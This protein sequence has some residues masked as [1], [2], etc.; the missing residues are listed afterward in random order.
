MGG[1]SRHEQLALG[2][3]PNIAAR[4]Q[5]LAEPNSVVMSA[6]TQR[7]VAGLFNCQDLGPQTL[8]GISIP[9]S[10]YRVSG[11]GAAQSRFDAAM[12]KGLTPLVGRAEELSL[13]QRR[14]EQ[15][16]AGDGQVVL[17]SGEPGIGKSR[18][19][20][21]LKEQFAHEGVTRIEFRCS[22]YHEKSALYP[23]IEQLQR[24]LAFAREDTS[25]AKLEKLQHTLSHYRFPQ[26]DTVPLIAALLSLPHSESSPR[27]A[28]SPQK[29]KEKTQAA[30]VAWLLEE[31]EH[32]TVYN[33]WEDMHWADPS[34]L[35]VL[36][37][38]VDQ[39]PTA[40]LY[41][42]LTFR[43]E[44]TPPW[45]NRSHVSQITLSRL[46]QRQVEAM[47]ECVTAGKALPPEVMRQIVV[48]TDGVPLFVEELTKTVIEAEVDV[49]ARHALPL[50]LAIPAT[51]Q[52]ALM[53]RLDRLGTAKEIAQLGATIGREFSYELLQAV[54]PLDDE[55]LQDGLQQLVA[56]ELVYQHGLL[57]QAHYLFK[58]ALIQDAAYQSLLKSKRHQYHE[59][60]GQVLEE[61]F[62]DTT[63][64]QPELVAHH[65]TEARL[66]QQALPYWLKAGQ[67][68]AERSAHAEAIGL[69]S[70]GLDLLRDLPETAERDRW[71]LA[72][73]T[74]LLPQL[75]AARG[76]ASPEVGTTSG[77][78]AE[79]CHRLGAV[80]QLFP[81][82]FELTLFHTCRAHH[83]A[84]QAVATDFIKL[85]RGA[86]D[87]VALHAAL[88][89]M[90]VS[91][92]WLG[93]FEI[94]NSHFEEGMSLFSPE[95]HRDVAFIYEPDPTAGGLGYW[96]FTLWSLGYP[97][98]ALQKTE[99]MLGLA[100]ELTLL[101]PSSLAMSLGHAATVH[102]FRGE[103]SM[104]LARA[105]AGLALAK[106]HG[107]R[108]WEAIH[109]TRVFAVEGILKLQDALNAYWATGFRVANSITFASLALAFGERA[110]FDEAERAMDE[111]FSFIEEA[112]ERTYEAEVHR[113]KGELL[114]MQDASHAARAEECFR[115][116][117]EIARRQRA[118]SWELRATTSLAG[119]LQK[120]RRRKEARDARR[121]PR[122]VHRGIRHRGSEGREGPPGR[123]VVTASLI[124][125]FSSSVLHCA[126]GSPSRGG[127]VTCARA[128]TKILPARA[129]ATAAGRPSR[130]SAPGAKSRTRP[131]P[132]FA[133]AAAGR[134]K[135]RRLQSELPIRAP[136]PPSTSPRRSSPRA[137]LSKVSASR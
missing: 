95:R 127:T 20:Q 98:Q 90:G 119:L 1:G 104:A 13:L 51:L 49:G 73:Q 74:A 47:V 45:R 63:K 88:V 57:P 67:V 18:L 100:Q 33:T 132:A 14:W 130:A 122:L 108:G 61:T 112:D 55:T 54:S 72:F 79:L 58:H 36:N 46:G 96:G 56:S 16:K 35:E 9:I 43:P 24:M 41:V 26:A 31:A 102:S 59:K 70:T 52:D 7:L 101:H 71:E 48:K 120:H 39:A 8:K 76:D 99:R 110:Q 2:E 23:I 50:P 34:T 69:L 6:A 25:A 109:R 3:T 78:A 133:T 68:A 94:A 84:A 128:A 28:V 17:L 40:S 65:Y 11:E 30:V 64:T 105:E 87:P 75:V 82:Q 118:K 137:V 92:Y 134:S 38:V 136:T 85:A 117:I 113:L 32:K 22:P 129:S 93:E 83:R 125:S 21:E 124:A 123:A 53:A 106:E 29:Q 66:V 121:N 12:H 111:A 89:V 86:D 37:L 42:L 131:A 97:D 77:R 116:A 60:I 80:S 19:V 81:V 10:A 15:A 5:G 103:T 115:G 4:M 27:I 107:L 91:S 114:L 135:R 62:P 44:F 126:R